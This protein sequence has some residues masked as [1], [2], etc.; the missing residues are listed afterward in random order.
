M[1]G[2]Y[3]PWC[4]SSHPQDFVFRGCL[5]LVYLFAWCY[6]SGA[7]NKGPT[8]CS[9]IFV[10]K[11]FWSLL[12]Q[13]T[14]W[15][16]PLLLFPPLTISTISN[17]AIHKIATLYTQRLQSPSNVL[18]FYHEAGFLSYRKLPMKPRASSLIKAPAN[19]KT[20]RHWMT[21]RATLAKKSKAISPQDIPQRP[22]GLLLLF[23][24]VRELDFVYR[25]SVLFQQQNLSGYSYHTTGLFLTREST[26]MFAKYM[27]T[28]KCTIN[29]QNVVSN[30][31]HCWFVCGLCMHYFVYMF[32]IYSWNIWYLL[33]QRLWHVSALTREY[34]RIHVKLEIQF[35][36]TL[37]C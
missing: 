3:P 5:K 23:Y 15:N 32:F 4:P 8:Q 14:V 29:D 33:R 20:M 28:Q 6:N 25:F 13:C 12:Q 17:K 9:P 34:I 36:T 31:L 37:C 16:C 26:A 21:C 30:S 24:F 11:S 10:P 22:C 27:Q 1:C 35:C 7:P 18:H 2:K 19:Y